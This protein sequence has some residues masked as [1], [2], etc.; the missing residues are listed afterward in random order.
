LV[1][2]AEQA[3]DA[4]ETGFASASSKGK[5]AIDNVSAIVEPLSKTGVRREMLVT[6]DGIVS[7][8]AG[9]DK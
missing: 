3:S 8:L 9:E 6:A 2:A 4:A 7:L 5:V 1:R